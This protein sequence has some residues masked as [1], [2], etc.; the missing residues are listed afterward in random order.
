MRK[1]GSLERLR[2]QSPIFS[3]SGDI[4]MKNREVSKMIPENLV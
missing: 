1:G 2:V 4:E 3:E